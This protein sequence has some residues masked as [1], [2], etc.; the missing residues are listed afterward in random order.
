V[1]SGAPVSAIAP[2]RGGVVWITRGADVLRTDGRH[3]ELLAAGRGDADAVGMPGI[4]A[5]GDHAYFTSPADGTVNRV[6]LAGGEAEVLASGQTMPGAV[7]VD[8][9]HV[10]WVDSTR[11]LVLK[12]PKPSAR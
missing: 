8:H 5:D 10:Y 3:A 4:A 6:A 1:W 12:A 11:G 9:D 2:I 7:A